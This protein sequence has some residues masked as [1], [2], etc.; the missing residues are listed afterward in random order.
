MQE[1]AVKVFD[2][3]GLLGSKNANRSKVQKK[4]NNNNNNIA[5]GRTC[6]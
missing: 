2:K 1:F 5:K 4:E 3:K 6:K